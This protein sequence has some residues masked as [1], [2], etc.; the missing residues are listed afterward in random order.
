MPFIT[1]GSPKKE[2]HP[3]EVVYLV[4]LIGTF[5]V[6]GAAIFLAGPDSWFHREKNAAFA[7]L[8]FALAVTGVLNLVIAA[9]HGKIWARAGPI[10]RSEHPRLF[11]VNRGMTVTITFVAAAGIV[12]LLFVLPPL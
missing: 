5:L 11:A 7:L 2:T 3:L 10:Y 1:P 12:L 6:T 9:N 8:L 4:L